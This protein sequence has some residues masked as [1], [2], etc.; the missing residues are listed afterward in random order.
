M[1]SCSND[2]DGAKRTDGELVGTWKATDI[3]TSGT[4]E[5]E[6]NGNP[7]SIP[8][9]ADVTNNNLTVTF[10]NDNTFT[11]TGSMDVDASI[12]IVGTTYDQSIDNFN[13]LGDGTYS[14]SGNTIT[15]TGNTE[16]GNATIEELTETVLILKLRNVV[17]TTQDGQDIT[18]TLDSTVEF[19][20][21]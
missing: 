3:S 12:S 21:Q 15:F 4:A 8:I 20:R 2:D 16:L 18:A 17:D 13:P 7:F 10:N 1:L 11:S 6:V 14:V 19:T 9:A 5:T